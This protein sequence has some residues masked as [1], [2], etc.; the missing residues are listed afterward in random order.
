MPLLVVIFVPIK[1]PVGLAAGA[2]VLLGAVYVSMVTALLFTLAL[3]CELVA[4]TTQRM[5]APLSA[6]YAG[7]NVFAVAPLISTVLR[8]HW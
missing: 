8:C 6:G 2:T 3:P 5:L 4:V 1:P 7:V